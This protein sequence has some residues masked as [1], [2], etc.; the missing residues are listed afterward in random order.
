MV[1]F[2]RNKMGFVL[3]KIVPATNGLTQ[4]LREELG[5]CRICNH[6]QSFSKTG[7]S[8]EAGLDLGASRVVR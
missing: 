7:P 3:R 4:Q 2:K 8:G 6:A 5:D 1:D